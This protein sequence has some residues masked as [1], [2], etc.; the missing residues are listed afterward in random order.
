MGEQRTGRQRRSSRWSVRVRLILPVVAVTIGV[1]AITAYGVSEARNL[2]SAER[3]FQMRSMGQAAKAVAEEFVAKE[4]SGA[5]TRAEAQQQAISVIKSMRYNGTEGYFWINDM[6]PT[7]IMHPIKPELDDQDATDILDGDKSQIFVVLTDIVKRSGSG[8]HYYHWP[9]PGSDKPV[10]KVA[11]VTGVP[12]WGWLIGTGSYVDDIEAAI[13]GRAM[14]LSVASLVVVLAVAALSLF[15]GRSITRPLR[16]VGAVLQ[17]LANG[18]LTARADI[19]GADEFA[20]IGRALDDALERTHQTVRAMHDGAGTL[21]TRSGDLSAAGNAIE[22][23]STR[24][25]ANAGTLQASTDRVAEAIQA[26]LTGTEQSDVHVQEIAGSTSEAAKVASE[27]VTLADTTGAAVGRLH[28]SSGRIIE[29]INLIRTIAEQTNLLALN[30]TIEAAR[31]GEAGKGFAVVAAEVKN[32]AQET[33]RATADV[34]DIVNAIQTDTDATVAAIASI[35]AVIGRIDEHQRGIASAVEQQAA[36]T[37]QITQRVADAAGQARLMTDVVGA[38]NDDIDRT[39]DTV[40]EVRA[41]TGSL[42]QLAKDMT[43]TASRFQLSATH[44]P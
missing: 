18:D 38:V 28:V 43:D 16:T 27:G 12:E 19:A 13:F 9:K 34:S 35:S 14:E 23:A 40:G 15:L 29:V 1:A 39:N 42:A 24:T 7:V 11:Y 31:A 3:E 8:F 17:R 36:T 32:L 33:E 22:A 21:V 20:R 25:A 5:L 41:A 26:V 4:R 37:A 2:A 6:H 30:A 44:G 10:A